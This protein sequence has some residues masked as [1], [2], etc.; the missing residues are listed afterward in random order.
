MIAASFS[1]S[2]QW[3]TD[4]NNAG[5]GLKLGLG[6]TS[7]NEGI[8]FTTEG[9]TKM[10]LTSKGWLG[11]SINQPRGWT[12]LN[13]CPP[14]GVGENGMIITKNNCHGG[15]LM[16][17]LTLADVIGQSRV[18]QGS[19]EPNSTIFKA[20]LNF[21]TGNT[22]N[23]VNPLPANAGSPMFWVR[24]QSQ[25]GFWAGSGPDKFDTK[26]IVMPDGSCGINVAQPRAALDVRGSNGLNK[27]AAII[28][29]R[30]IGTHVI[31]NGLV[32]YYTQQVHFVPV[33]TENG[34]NQ[35][36]HNTDQ[37]MFFTDGKGKTAANE[38]DGSNLDGAFVLAPWAPQGNSDIGGMRMDKNGNTEFHGTLRATK[39]N[40]DAKWWADFVF[41]DEYKLPSLAEVESYIAA[42]KH[43][44]D[45]P[46]E[47]KVLENG[48][49]LA[50]MQ[51]I[52]QQKIEELTLYIIQQ[53]K[54]IDQLIQ[55]VTELKK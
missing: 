17:D 24:E 53:Q 51:A 39:M 44:P 30:A 18:P 40:V 29:S 2:A 25:S 4:G 33:L 34:Y 23:L 7:P 43:L 38:N 6:A 20:P 49:D 8:D 21:L 15:T 26:F 52:Q 10:S 42:N 55:T 19:N 5:S 1:A 41:D 28:G 11:I 45:M 35:I 9:T 13:Y 37:G 12:E 32:Y 22:T 48:L 47:A 14:L 16:R 31:D 36:V 3:A 27:P 46:S 50:N 54:Q